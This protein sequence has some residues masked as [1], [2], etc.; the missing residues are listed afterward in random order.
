MRCVVYLRGRA[1][2]SADLGARH[3]QGLPLSRRLADRATL[4]RPPRTI[5]K[6]ST[7]RERSLMYVGAT[8]ATLRLVVPAHESLREQLSG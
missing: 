1:S 5:E 7:P 4:A 6:L 8:W 3:S 2:P